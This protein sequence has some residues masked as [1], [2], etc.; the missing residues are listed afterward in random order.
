MGIYL[1]RGPSC[2]G[3]GGTLLSTT[4][5]N[6]VGGGELSKG[7]AIHRRQSKENPKHQN[8]MAKTSGKN[9]HVSGKKFTLCKPLRITYERERL[10]GGDMQPQ[11]SKAKEGRGEKK[12]QISRKKGMKER[13]V[14]THPRDPS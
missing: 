6:V 4:R 9:C 14:N 10:Y 7:K 3:E 12:R 5:M 2:S 8:P 11:G 13:Q 1:H